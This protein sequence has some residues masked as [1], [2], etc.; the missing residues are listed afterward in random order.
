MIY[1][2]TTLALLP[3]TLGAV[4]PILPE[5]YKT[6]AETGKPLGCFSCDF[7][8]L[9]R[10]TLLTAYDDAEALFADRAR[11]LKSADPY[12]IGKYLGSVTS[13]AY[14]PFAFMGDIE[15]GSFGPFYEIRTYAVAPGGMPSTVDAWSKVIE[16]RQEM[17]KLLTVMQSI[18]STPQTMVHI[19][20]Y[21]SIEERSKA[22][23]QA[24]KEGIWPPAGSGTHLTAMQSELFVATAFS[25]LK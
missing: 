21:S 12:G 23:A 24:S 11:I 2:L 15:T 8:V 4:L 7:G 3:N 20:P 9:N 5:T 14:E 16:R 19:W 6:Y 10:F 25:D 13:A 1:D 17:S 22:R 18:G